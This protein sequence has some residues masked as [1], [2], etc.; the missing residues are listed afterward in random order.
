MK[1]HLLVATAAAALV[2]AGCSG[3]STTTDWDRTVDFSG[4]TTYSW[5]VTQ[6]EATNDITNNRI[7]AAIDAGLA[8]RGLRKVDSGADLAVGYQVSTDQQTSYT[9]MSTGWGTGWGG[10]WG[11]GWGMGTSQTTQQTWNVGTIVLAMFEY[12]GQTMVWTG[13]ASADIDGNRSPED[14]ED[15]INSAVTKMLS[16]F[17]PEA[18]N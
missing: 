15:Q 11:G 13:T 18:S 9:T 10:G 17:P 1:H 6:G 2:T 12:A 7:K 16:D 8:A 4:F 3:I 14:R 5:I